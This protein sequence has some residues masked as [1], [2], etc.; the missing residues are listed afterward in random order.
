MSRHSIFSPNKH[1][2]RHTCHLE[3]FKHVA[4]LP[5]TLPPRKK[6]RRKQEGR[7]EKKREEREE[8]G[9]EGGKGK[10]GKKSVRYEIHANVCEDV[11]IKLHN[12]SRE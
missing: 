1:R 12:L 9:K 3:R 7:G 2:E 6:T 10:E 11:S 8:G 4:C 5:S